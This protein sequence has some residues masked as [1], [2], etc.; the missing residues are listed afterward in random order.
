MLVENGEVGFGVGVVVGV[1]DADD[2]AGALVGDLVEAVGVADL[3]RRVPIGS[4]ERDVG[5]RMNRIRRAHEGDGL[6]TFALQREAKG[7]RTLGHERSGGAEH[8]DDDGEGACGAG[9]NWDVAGGADCC[10]NFVANGSAESCRL[11]THSEPPSGSVMTGSI[12]R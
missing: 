8:E 6:G 9:T 5:K 7:K 3:R 1:N 12:G 4:G 2:L 10:V 11:L